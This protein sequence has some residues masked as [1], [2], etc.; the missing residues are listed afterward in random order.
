L[1]AAREFIHDHAF[2]PISV[3]EIAQAAGRH[4]IHLAREFR[5]RFGV[6]I[7]AYLRRLRTEEAAR[8]LERPQ[9]DI[10]DVALSCGFASHSHLC[11]VFRAHFGVTPSHYRSRHSH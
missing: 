9:A 11:R 2:S 10:T 7:G 6:S 3:A 8:L 1:K 5:R 4:E